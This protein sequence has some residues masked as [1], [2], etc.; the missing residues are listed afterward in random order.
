MI[1]EPTRL[2]C[3]IPRTAGSNINILAQ[4]PSTDSIMTP[5]ISSRYRRPLLLKVMFQL[6]DAHL[7]TKYITVKMTMPKKK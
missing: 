7:T 6:P 5:K 3:I 1:M 4:R 2:F